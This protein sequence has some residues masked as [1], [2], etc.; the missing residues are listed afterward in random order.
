MSLL[1]AL[2]DFSFE[3]LAYV[4]N[5]ISRDPLKLWSYY[6]KPRN[7][8]NTLGGNPQFPVGMWFD[9]SRLD[10]LQTYCVQRDL[11]PELQCAFKVKSTSSQGTKFCHDIFYH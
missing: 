1:L 9:V 8:G 10:I 5:K 3:I 2:I 4:V 6:P 11:G 7:T